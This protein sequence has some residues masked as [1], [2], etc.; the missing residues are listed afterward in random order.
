MSCTHPALFKTMCV[1]C[2]KIIKTEPTLGKS[3][4]QLTMH[5]GTALQVS[6][7][8]AESIQANKISN[9]RIMKKIALV[10]D[11][12][13][14]LLHAIQVD[15]PTP[16]VQKQAHEDIFH[17]PIEE[18]I[19]GITKHLIMKKR[20]HLDV[21]LE[22]C[23]EFCQMTIYTAGTRRYAEAVAKVIDPTHKYFSNRIV[24]RTDNPNVK[25][26]GHDKSLERI[27]LSDSSMAVIIDDRE[28]VWKGAGANNPPNNSN[29]SSS[30]DP[31]PSTSNNANT[32]GDS[33]QLLLARP[34]IYFNSFNTNNNV[35]VEANNCSGQVSALGGNSST[36]NSTAGSGGVAPGP[37]TPVIS[38]AGMFC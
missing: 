17:L 5:G 18:M 27:F 10:L 2:G 24:S 3:T 21:F 25:S 8:E 28:D 11:L 6:A 33:A 29:L 37:L 23:H 22:K 35:I 38:L 34:F 20:P 1:S 13:H 12:D 19:N 32:G 9:L 4:S 31:T 26:D 30:V 7:K 14:T 36:Q 16:S 15:G